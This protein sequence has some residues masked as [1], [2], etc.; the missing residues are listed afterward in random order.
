MDP[1]WGYLTLGQSLGWDW[2]RPVPD[3]R[4]RWGLLE[5]WGRG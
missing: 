1:V 4:R 5:D 2:V 3:M